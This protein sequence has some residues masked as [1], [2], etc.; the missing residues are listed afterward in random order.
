MNMRTVY[1]YFTL[2]K[3]CI[4]RILYIIDYSQNLRLERCP[5]LHWGIPCILICKLKLVLERHW[6]SVP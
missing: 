2:L 4:S 6:T 1:I 5:A 3:F